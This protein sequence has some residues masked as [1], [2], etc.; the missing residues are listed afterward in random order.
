M[1]H[2]RRSFLTS[3]L[4]FLLTGLPGLAWNRVND[5][6]PEHENK[7]ALALERETGGHRPSDS[8][9]ITVV[10]PEIAEDGSIVPLGISTELPN[11]GTIWVFVEK[12]P[13][14]LAAKFEV[15]N[16]LDPFVSLRV[17]MNESCEVIAMVKSGDGYFIARKK[18]RVVQGGCG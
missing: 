17:K 16:S 8:Q 6:K 9:L 7:L 14:P 11:V 15:D 4:G 13:T 18:V 5:P 2:S 1:V 3:L 10:A 12:N